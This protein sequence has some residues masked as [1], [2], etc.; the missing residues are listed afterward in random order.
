[1]TIG[2]HVRLSGVILDEGVTLEDEVVVEGR[3][4]SGTPP[5]IAAGSR[6]CKGTHLRL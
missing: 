5:V 6:L 3:G 2:N 1:V 4:G